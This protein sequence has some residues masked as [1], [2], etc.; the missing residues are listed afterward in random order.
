MTVLAQL[1]EIRERARKGGLPVRRK[2]AE[3]YSI[4][5][6]IYRLSHDID[7]SSARGTLI[8][9]LADRVSDNRNRV[10][11][12][13]NTDNHLLVCRYVLEGEDNRNS[14][15]RYAMALKEAR[16][17]EIPKGGLAAW[18]CEN[19]GVNRLFKSRP[20][21]KRSY[22]TS[23]LQLKTRITVPKDRP[24]TITLQADERG[25]YDVLDIEKDPAPYFQE[26]VQ[27]A[28]PKSHK[29]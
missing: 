29:D 6:E 23:A 27:K 1:D 16:K 9:T 3:L 22:D 26:P 21:L 10:Y 11:V 7:F 25:Y 2:D 15:Y 20:L 12:Q 28:K 24:F 18:L 17:R 5:A 4:L 13:H 19:G 8:R 14:I